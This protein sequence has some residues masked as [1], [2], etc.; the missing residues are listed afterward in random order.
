MITMKA[1]LSCVQAYL[2]RIKKF[3]IK[4]LRLKPIC[5]GGLI[6]D[7]RCLPMIP[8]GEPIIPIFSYDDFLKSIPKLTNDEW[9][10]RYVQ[11]EWVEHTVKTG[12]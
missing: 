2:T 3:I 8:M 10:R 7:N 4:I 5:T 1:D 9:F 11:G 12:N 6:T